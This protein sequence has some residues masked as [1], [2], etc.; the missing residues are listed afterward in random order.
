MGMKRLEIAAPRQVHEKIISGLK[1]SV[2]S[3]YYA[4]VQVA[5]SGGIG[6]YY[7]STAV[8]NNESFKINCY[9]HDEDE[10]QALQVV[11]EVIS[12]HPEEGTRFVIINQDMP[13]LELGADLG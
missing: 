13:A 10:Q 2:S 7:F 9:L 3:F 4:P 11:T 8:Q 5:H 12:A 6:R 1:K